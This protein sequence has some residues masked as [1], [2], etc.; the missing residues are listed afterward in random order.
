MSNEKP[1]PLVGCLG[2]FSGMKYYPGFF[3]D[4]FINHDMR[5]PSL[6]NQ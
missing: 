1:G 3:G 5:I 2:Y 4:Y 6:T